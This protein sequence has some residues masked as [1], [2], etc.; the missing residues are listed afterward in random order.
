MVDLSALLL[1]MSFWSFLVFWVFFDNNIP[2]K[3]NI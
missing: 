2:Q 3:A 1:N